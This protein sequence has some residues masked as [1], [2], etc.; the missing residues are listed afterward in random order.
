MENK[1][2]A[3]L[4]GGRG[5]VPFGPLDR[6]LFLEEVAERSECTDSETE[7][8]L[9]LDLL[10]FGLEGGEDSLLTGSD[11]GSSVSLASEPSFLRVN[12]RPRDLAETLIVFFS[13]LSISPLPRKRVRYRRGMKGKGTYSPCLGQRCRISS[14]ST[15]TFRRAL[16]G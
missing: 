5:V 15:G 4:I 13:S 10:G 12:Q 9:V 14:R 1:V 2:A 16:C 8:R 11:S 7:P 3:R 6:L